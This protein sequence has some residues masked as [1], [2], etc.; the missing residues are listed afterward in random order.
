MGGARTPAKVRRLFLGT[1][2]SILLLGVLLMITVRETLSSAA[3]SRAAVTMSHERITRLHTLLNALLEAEVGQRGYVITGD[4]AFLEP[5]ETAL[6]DFRSAM[7]ILNHIDRQRATILSDLIRQKLAFVAETVALRRERGLDAAASAIRTGRGKQLM[8]QIRTLLDDLIA[9]EN[10]ELTRRE[11]LRAANER[12]ERLTI[13]SALGGVLCVIM[14]AAFSLRRELHYRSLA[15]NEAKRRTALLHGTLENLDHGVAL[16]GTQGEVVEHN[17][18][19]NSFLNETS[20]ER[21]GD[22]LLSAFPAELLTAAAAARP[23]LEVVEHEDGRSVEVRGSPTPDGAYVVTFTDI[24]ARRRG[25]NLRSAFISNVS[26]ELRTPLTS[27][28]AS[29]RL[30][31]GP[32]KAEIPERVIKLVTIA[33]RN[34]DSLLKLVN[35]L[36]D[37]D[38]LESGKMMIEL[39]SVDLNS[40]VEEAVEVNRGYAEAR[41][42]SIA[43]GAPSC[44]VNVIA[45]AARVQQVMANLLSNAAKFSPDGGTVVISVEKREN[46]ARVVVHDDGPGIPEHFRSEM[47]QKFSQARSSDSTK[48][49]GS[50]LGLNIAKAIVEAHGGE[51]SYDSRPGD[52]NFWFTLPLQN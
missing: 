38:K 10:A 14:I 16:L 39:D 24:S 20:T 15:E 50:G 22:G 30:M 45:D 13:Y 51:L 11:E 4:A 9:E 7:V 52:T 1:S 23:M 44:P 42:I 3:A 2:L 29:L 32:L 33:D 46:D 21:A 31:A 8:D 40:V 6:A 28:R 12:G 43:V 18:K 49:G 48:L 26:H 17:A 5:Y 47:F 25:E 36:L 27:I 41:Q 19:L 35:D 37:I 34:T